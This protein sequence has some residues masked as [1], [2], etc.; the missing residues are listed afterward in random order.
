M[1]CFRFANGR[2]RNND[3]LGNVVCSGARPA[4]E[5]AEPPEGRAF[6][7]KPGL[8]G[9]APIPR[10]YGAGYWRGGR[11]THEAHTGGQP[12]FHCSRAN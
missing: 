2:R 6:R 7:E 11:L 12:H 10:A 1:R 5:I 3:C 4:I 8:L 9:A